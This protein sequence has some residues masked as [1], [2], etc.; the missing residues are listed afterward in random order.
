MAARDTTAPMMS[1]TDGRDCVGFILRRHW[2][3]GYAVAYEGFDAN[4][5]SLG[6]FD[7]QDKAAAEVWRR[8]RGQTEA[9][10]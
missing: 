10:P 6:I 9:A 1:V 8:A 2:I 7:S 5:Q 3:D 4:Q